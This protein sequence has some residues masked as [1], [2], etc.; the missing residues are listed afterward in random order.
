MG[1]IVESV[2][3]DGHGGDHRI[4]LVGVPP[5]DLVHRLKLV[6]GRVDLVEDHQQ[7]DVRLGMGIARAQEPNSSTRRRRG[8]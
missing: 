1:C 7:V 4:V 6:P 2:L 5:Q 3:G 8:P